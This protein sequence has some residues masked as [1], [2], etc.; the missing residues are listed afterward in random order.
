MEVAST[1]PI[2]EHA[3]VTSYRSNKHRFF[4]NVKSFLQEQREL[5]E[6]KINIE[7]QFEWQIIEMV[8]HAPISGGKMLNDYSPYE[9]PHHSNL[10]WFGMQSASQIYKDQFNRFYDLWSVYSPMCARCRLRSYINFNSHLKK[11]HGA[12]WKW[13][14]ATVLLIA[15]RYTRLIATKKRL[16]KMKTE[17]CSLIDQ[18]F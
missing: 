13:Y 2:Q 9:Q 15:A 14:I 11:N 10:I 18:L 4:S 8:L 16:I 3:R 6:R 7:K 5:E 12:V 1:L 17:K